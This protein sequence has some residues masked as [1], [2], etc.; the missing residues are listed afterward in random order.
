VNGFYAL[1][2]DDFA[3]SCNSNYDTSNEFLFC[4]FG[5]NNPLGNSV[6]AGSDTSIVKLGAWYYI[7][8][9]FDGVQSKLY[10]NGQ[11]KSAIA[12]SDTFTP[13]SDSLYIGKHG[14]PNWPY[15]FNGVIDQ[16]RIYNR[17]LSPGAISQLMKFEY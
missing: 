11:L 13:N 6:G 12:K 15:F 9:T 10:I 3:N 17:A 16:I 14:D 2:F 4:F 1:R 7:V 8:Y 5:D